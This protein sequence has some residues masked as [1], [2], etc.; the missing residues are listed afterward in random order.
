MIADAAL[1]CAQT[2]WEPGSAEGVCPECG[3]PLEKKGKKKRCLQTRGGQE[4]ELEREYGVCPSCGARDFSPW[5]KSWACC[6]VALTPHGYEC[7]VRLA[8]WMPFGQAAKLLGDFLGIHVSQGSSNRYTEAAGA[9][10]VQ[11]QEDE[12]DRLEREAPP[13]EPGAAEKLQVSVD[14]AMVPLRHGI[15]AEVKTLVIGEVQ[16]P[17]LEPSGEQ[18]VHTR[19]LSYFSRK[20]TAEEF[21]RLALVEVHRRGVEAAPQVAAIMDGAEWEQGF[22]D[23]HCPRATRILDFPHA[24][25]HADGIARYHAPNYRRDKAESGLQSLLVIEY[26]SDKLSDVS[27]GT[28][29]GVALADGICFARDLSNEPPNVLFPEEMANRAKAMAKRTGLKFSVL[30]EGEMRKLGMNIL[31]AVSQGSAREAQLI[32]ME[33]APKGK[34]KD[35]PLVLVGKGVTFDTGGISLKPGERMEEMKHDM[36]GAA[37]VI[38]AMEAIAR[39]GVDRRVIGVA[40]CVENMPDG[41]AFRPGDIL[42]GITGK[43]TEILST[44]AEGRLILADAL[45]YVARYNPKAVVDAATLTGAIGVALGPYAAGLFVNDDNL[46]DAMLAASKRSAERIWHMPLYDEYMDAI[47]GDMAEVKNSGGRGGGVGTSA[48]FIEHFTEGYPWAHLDIANVA[49]VNAERDPLNAKGATGFG[50]RLFVEL[51]KAY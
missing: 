13:V 46:K 41:N 11:M 17:V 24:A 39:L 3:R 22:A 35:A 19:H 36:G 44:D 48:K 9:A 25:E 40:V 23:Y 38:G 47:K 37:A 18:V 12:V 1:A 42:T 10:Y 5:M 14:G 27:R 50:V 15:W 2:D 31:L 8:S 43:T 21:Q 7:L 30:G 51:A 26:D 32:I 33:H 6:R 29:N 28:A 4:V 49:W 16:P 34:T 45:G 20:E